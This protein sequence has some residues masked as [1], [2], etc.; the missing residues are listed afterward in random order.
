MVGSPV[1]EGVWSNG[2]FTP[3]SHH[4]SK[5]RSSPESAF[6]GHQISIMLCSATLAVYPQKHIKVSSKEGG[7]GCLKPYRP[8][9]KSCKK[10][11]KDYMYHIRGDIVWQYLIAQTEHGN[12]PSNTGTWA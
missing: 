12:G 10:P 4:S 11:S 2:L 8:L 6:V 5:G 7:V 9:T 3:R 1:V